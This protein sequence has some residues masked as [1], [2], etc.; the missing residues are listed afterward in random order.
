MAELFLLSGPRLF[1]V[2]K[3][4]RA[5]PLLL[6]KCLLCAPDIR[7]Y[8]TLSSFEV[9]SDL[10]LTGNQAFYCCRETYRQR[11]KAGMTILP[12]TIV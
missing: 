12:D 11:S 1:C 2:D 4:A 6:S 3:S 9:L 8:R 10:M 5:H 7:V